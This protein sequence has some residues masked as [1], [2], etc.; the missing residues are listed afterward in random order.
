MSKEIWDVIVIGGGP[1]GMM[2]ASRAAELGKNVL[3]LE[4]NS[5]LGEKLLITGG[6][7]CNV[8]NNKPDIHQLVASYRD[9]PKALYSI[10]SQYGV[11]DTLEFFNRNGMDTKVEA[12]DRV[13][14][15][16]DSAVSVW[17][18][19]LD[20]LEEYRVS[21]ESEVEV[22]SLTKN[23][24]FQVKL[25]NGETRLAKSV[26]IAT[27]GTSRPDTG[28]TGDGFKWLKSFGHKI[29]DNNMALVP[30]A[31]KE[32][33]VKDV[34]GIALDNAKISIH[35]DE[36]K[37]ESKFGKVLFTHFGLSGPG[38]LNLSSR[39]GDVLDNG[40][41]QIMIDLLPKTDHGSLKNELYS[42]LDRNQNKMIKNVLGEL[43][44]GRLV[45]V[46]LKLSNINPD[47]FNHSLTRDERITIINLIKGIKLTVDSLLGKD[48]AIVSSGGVDINE[49]NFQTMESKIVE[50]LYVVGDVLNI[51]RP[52]GGYSLQIC[53]SSGY[54]A[55]S[56]A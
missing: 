40:V 52:S 32:N 3:L 29:H 10:F 20:I 8:T 13:F 24:S 1:S 19:L 5:R 48:K 55:G 47:K 14:P 36:K 31:T 2:A 54:V 25:S 44:P 21:V 26:I 56:N 15:V 34:S 38:I 6:G 16:S 35:V 37:I 39:I 17:E 41:V 9:R 45:N 50:G 11:S 53:W 4:K 49:I 51:D 22:K 33:W 27:G 42:L 7:R 30:I 43:I 46:I 12:E 23:N 18:V 28:S